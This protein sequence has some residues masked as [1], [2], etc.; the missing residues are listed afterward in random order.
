MRNCW[1]PSDEFVRVF[2]ETL[3]LVRTQT[4]SPCNLS[5]GSLSPR[6][7]RSVA[8]YTPLLRARV[9][10][11]ASVRARVNVRPLPASSLAPRKLSLT[12]TSPHLPHGLCLSLLP[13]RPSPF[14]LAAPPHSFPISL[15]SLHST[16][17][18]FVYFSC[19]CRGEA[20]GD[21]GRGTL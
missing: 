10:V 4:L 6:P 5:A 18:L 3:P 12:R 2:I 1:F 20:G 17:R 7:L 15:S 14:S 19:G 8:Q 11:R 9:R 16:L 21:R 13:S